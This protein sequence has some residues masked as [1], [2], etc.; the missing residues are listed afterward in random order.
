MFA[1][2]RVKRILIELK[3][4]FYKEQIPINNL[5]L[6]ENSVKSNYNQG[7]FFGEK[8]KY[9]TIEGRISIPEEWEPERVLIETFTSK[10]ESDNSTN[11]QMKLYIDDKL[12]QGLDVNHQEVVL[13][14]W[15]VNQKKGNLRL[16]IFSG[17]EEKKFPVY[18]YLTHFDPLVQATYYDLKVALQS[19][20]LLEKDSQEYI[21]MKDILSNA[22][23][24]LDFRSPYSQEFIQSLKKCRAYLKENLYNKECSS[25]NEVL[26][27]GHTHI[28]VAWLWTVEQAIEKG[29]RS[30]STVLK[31]MEEYDS[32]TFI[33]SQPQLYE[34]IK[35][36]YPN[37]YE[38]IKE[39]VIIGKWEPE[40]AM[41]VEAD[42]NLASGESLVRQILYGKQFFLE[43]FGV[44]SKI[45]WLPDVFGYS[46][47][48][49]QIL[50]KT[51]IDYF[52]TTKLSWNQFNRIPFDTFYWKGIDG[53][54][55]LTHFI[56]TPSENYNPTP[57]YA[58][59]NG[60][61]DPYS[62]KGTWDRYQQKELNNEVLLAYGYGDGG[63]GPTRDMLETSKRLEKGLPGIPK[64]KNGH[65]LDF[66]ERLEKRINKE[67][68][69]RWMGELYFEYHRG[70]YTSIAKIK[71][72]NREA[73]F[74]LQTIEKLYSLFLF[75]QYPKNK[76][77]ELWKLL[78]LNQFHDILPGSSIKEVYDDS[79]LD[80]NKI[81]EN[82]ERLLKKGL[83]SQEISTEGAPGLLVFNSLG[84]ERD[85]VIEVSL[86]DDEVLYYK[87]DKLLTQKTFDNRQIAKIP[88]VPGFGLKTISIKKEDS[89]KAKEVM[90]PQKL[91][92]S[93]TTSYY[94]IEFNK[95]YEIISLFDKEN[96]REILPADTIFNRLIVYEDLPMNYDAWDIDIY[97]KEKS[98][99]VDDVISAKI[100]EEGDI[101]DTIEIIRKFKDSTIKQYIHFYK[102]NNR[103][104]FQ[105]KVDWQQSHLLLRAEFPID[106]H[107]YNADFDIQFGNI[108]RPIHKNTSWDQARFEV[109]GHKWMDFSENNYGISFL[110]DSKYGYS[111][112]YKKA[113]ISLIKSPTDPYP[114]AD[115]GKH[116][117][118][119]AVLPH[120]KDWRNAKTVKQAFDLNVPLVQT[121]H[122]IEDNFSK[123][124]VDIKSENDSVI[125]DTIKQ[126]E[127]EQG[128]IL[129]FYEY[130]GDRGVANIKFNHNFEKAFICNLLEQEEN[131]ITFDNENLKVEF[132]PYEIITIKLFSE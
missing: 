16:E 21:I 11:P 50:E 119:Y 45:L 116:E 63:G 75:D 49:P 91:S 53:T 113:G 61:L 128:I 106:I 65:P 33:Q 13:P 19:W 69:P 1:Q 74:L 18:I 101:R 34:F 59:Y 10:T 125:I 122:L 57:Y 124:T 70:T 68:I 67:E 81:F 123:S 112:D 60:L 52:M 12:I 55:I 102:N 48:L 29:E 76:L 26:V 4:F 3:R 14:D 132:K 99:V 46:A 92:Q 103:I 37:L 87:K 111:A 97:Y 96:K 36:R 20:M 51:N 25:K 32:F 5:V 129:R 115:I 89:L 8:N 72:D 15:I 126:S 82:G 7:D 17:R 43:E 56:T 105:T 38:K 98:W 44:D 42:T 22:V 108:E 23:N 9:Y 40:G 90:K 84:F 28:D 30:F 80:Y 71:K 93:F 100:V 66:F 109:S 62:V 78:L 94:D 118:T 58:T 64:I 104:D 86:K 130:K 24:I 131:E 73:E 88:Q 83:K 79:D 121:N 27:V 39:Q 95:N 6:T 2:E 127:D 120:K 117:F 41:W 85:S 110:T 54:E 114:N 47:A 107:T 35:K 31:F 77:E